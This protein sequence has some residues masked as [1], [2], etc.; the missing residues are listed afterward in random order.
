M[1]FPGT[2]ANIALSNW[3]GIS[4]GVS[5]A[6]IELIVLGIAT[7]M[8]EGV[9]LTSVVNAIYG[10]LMVDFFNLIIPAH[11]LAILGLPLMAIGWCIMDSS[12]FGNCGSNM[13][14]TAILKRSKRSIGFI[15]T[16]IECAYLAI[17]FLGARQSVT[18]CTLLLSF[19]FGYIMQFEYKLLKYN[20][21]DTKH[22][23]LI[24]RKHA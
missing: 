10:N 20:P 7:Y 16:A 19:G 2:S 15:R 9:G 11:P 23:F 13:L 21:T 24:K 17:G 14:T 6:I 12:G 18:L 5:G 1:F 3:F 8:R 22:Q 4:I